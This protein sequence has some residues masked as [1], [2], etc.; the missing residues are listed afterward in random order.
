MQITEGAH[1]LLPHLALVQTT[2]QCHPHHKQ[3]QGQGRAGSHAPHFGGPG[4][5]LLHTALNHCF[6]IHSLEH[7]HRFPF[8]VICTSKAPCFFFLL[9]GIMPDLELSCLVFPPFGLSEMCRASVWHEQQGLLSEAVEM[10]LEAQEFA[11]VAAL[12]EQSMRPHYV[13][14]MREHYTLQRWLVALPDATLEQHPRLCVHAVFLLLFSWGGHGRADCRPATLAQIERLLHCAER[15]WQAEGNHSGL[16]QILT[17]RALISKEQGELARAARFAREALDSL[18]ESE[19]PWRGT[20]LRIIGEEELQAGRTRVA[21]QLF[22]EAWALLAATGNSYAVRATQLLLAEACLLQGELHQAAELYRAVLATAE[23]DLFDTGQA[24][25]GLARLSYEWDALEEAWQEAQEAMA[26]G[27]QIGEETLRV[28][29]ALVLAMIEQARGEIAA[30]GLRLCVLFA[31]LPGE[32]TPH[33]PLLQRR[34]E[35]VQAHLALA[36][37]DLAT[38]ERWS[39]TSASQRERLPR[40]H[41][42][43]EDLIV[44]RLLIAQG[45]TEEALHLLEGWQ[46]EAH[47]QGRR[48]SELE[49]LVLI[50]RAAFAQQRQFHAFSRLREALALAQAEDYQRLFLD[51]GEEMAALLRAALPTI[52]KNHCEPYV[53][54]LLRAFAQHHLE[55]G[56]ALDSNDSVAAASLSPLSPQEQRVLRLLVAG[57]SNPEIAEALVVSINT[58]KTQIRSIYRKLSV[59]S[60]REARSAVLSQNLL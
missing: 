28:Q 55:Q 29:A 48:R 2:P 6:G 3:H 60:R 58:V 22:Q 31:R 26:L 37:G 42:E 59:K 50:A 25:L 5:T 38:A 33:L 32:A 12:L 27:T 44:A 23:E 17:F 21:R 14:T 24:Q 56:A 36:A 39:T 19:S 7:R 8:R 1:Q 10:A 51:E 15:A 11:R 9:S 35:A 54:M 18:A 30:A 20:C 57:Y 47:E 46:V 43:Y 52:K 53:R 45:K 40:L 41:Q 13:Y 4:L 34:I 49:I 16:G